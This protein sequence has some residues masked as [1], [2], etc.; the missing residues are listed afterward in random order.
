MTCMKFHLPISIFGLTEFFELM[1][2]VEE[3]KMLRGFEFKNENVIGKT[4]L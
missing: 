4:I 3:V 2:S 1:E